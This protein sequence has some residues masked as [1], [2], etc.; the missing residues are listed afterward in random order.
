MRALPIL[1]LYLSNYYKDFPMKPMSILLAF[2]LLATLMSCYRMPRDDE[3]SVLPTTNN[4]AVTNQRQ[5]AFLP[6]IG[7]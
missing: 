1:V 3:Y 7:I 2:C 6:A 5:E 4:P